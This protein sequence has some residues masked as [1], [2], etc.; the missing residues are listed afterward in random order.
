MNIETKA[1]RARRELQRFKGKEPIYP[2]PEPDRS[3][4]IKYVGLVIDF[5]CDELPDRRLR[6]WRQVFTA[7]YE[8]TGAALAQ[9]LRPDVLT[10]S[11][12]WAGV[13]PWDQVRYARVYTLNPRNTGPMDFV[14]DVRAFIHFLGRKGVLEEAVGDELAAGYLALSE[15]VSAAG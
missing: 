5:M 11:Q 8:L 12:A 10:E 4:H 6:H 1:R 13:D 14:D 3:W 7:L 15:D 2:L 9:F